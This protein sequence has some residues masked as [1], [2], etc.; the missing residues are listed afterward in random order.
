MVEDFRFVDGYQFTDEEEKKIRDEYGV[1]P[2]VINRLFAR[3][4]NLQGQEVQTRTKVNYRARSHDKQEKQTAEALSALAMF[5]QD[6]NNSTHIL[7]AVA[8]DSRKCGLGWHRFDV[9]D[10]VI[11]EEAENPLFVVPDF[12]DM[13][14]GMTNQR[15]VSRFYWMPRDEA[16]EDFP[17]ATDIID[18]ASPQW[19][20]S[21]LTEAHKAGAFRLTQSGC[22]YDQQTDEICIVE[23]FMR[24]PAEYYEVVTK[25]NRLVTTFSK[26]EADGMARSK[27]DVTKR[28]GFK[29]SVVYFTGDQLLS[30]LDEEET[31]QL[32]PAK[33][34]ISLTPTVCFRERVSGCPYG[35]VR[36]AKDSQ[37]SFNKTKTRLGWLRTAHQVIMEADAA[38]ADKVRSEAARPDGVLIVKAGKK[39]EINRHEQAIAQHQAGLVA[40]DQDIQATLGVFDESMGMETNADSGIAIQRR[41]VGTSRNT[42]SII[43]NALAAKKRWA[44]KLLYLIQSVFTDQVAFWVLDDKN[45]MKDLVLNQPVIGADGKPE[46]DK[47]TGKPVMKYDIKT[48]AFDVFVEEVPDVA[49]MREIGQERF[50]KAVQ[51]A[52]GFQNITPGYAMFFDVPE[53]SKL[54]QEIEAGLPQQLAAAN[55]T[56]AEAGKGLASALTPAPTPMAGGATPVQ[57]PK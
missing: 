40:D 53:N 27:E 50:M 18:N 54:M 33:G 13:S 42:A 26:T 2:M 34:L 43:D 23:H 14:K 31:Y 37:R 44:E 24:T 46:I 36:H 17:D 49:S 7:S 51:A 21:G 4:N 10:G 41:Q 52:G 29:V 25:D 38:D 55:T 3:L 1:E 6:K 39:L 30:H 8:D 32:N 35:L 9:V 5:I 11:G 45:E 16:K 48:G 28:Q 47:K 22:Y 56:A 19:T 15:Q 12:R 20:V 57:Q